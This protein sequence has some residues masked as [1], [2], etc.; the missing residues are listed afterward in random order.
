MPS[1]H[2]PAELVVALDDDH[3]VAN[4]GLLLPATL[5]ERL[6]IGQSSTSWSHRLLIG[7]RLCLVAVAGAVPIWPR[8]A[9]PGNRRLRALL[10]RRRG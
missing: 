6:G 9:E 1:T 5:A 3:A 7:S 10:R 4:A 2:S 8:H